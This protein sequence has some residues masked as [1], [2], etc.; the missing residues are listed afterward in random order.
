MGA[1]SL[2]VTMRLTNGVP[3]ARVAEACGALSQESRTKQCKDPHREAVNGAID[4][5][6]DLCQGHPSAKLHNIALQAAFP[7]S[8]R[9]QNVQCEPRSV[10]SCLASPGLSWGAVLAGRRPETLNPTP[11]NLL[12]T[13]HGGIIAPTIPLSEDLLGA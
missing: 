3:C 8:D 12:E 10:R 9:S 6:Q 13:W 4:S 1:V 7:G 11:L 2:R 5:L